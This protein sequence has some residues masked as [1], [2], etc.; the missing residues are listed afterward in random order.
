MLEIGSTAPD[1]TL[2][3][4]GGEDVTLSAL[5]GQKVVLYFYPKDNTPGCTTEALDFTAL[6]DEFAAAGALVFGVSKDSVKKHENFCAK[7]SLGIPLLSDENGSVCEDYG[8]WQEKSMYGKTF[9]GIVRATFL[10]DED[11][12]VAQ[13]WP[14]VK[15]AGHAAEVLEAVKA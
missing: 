1:F 10:I 14:K 11:G 13:V 2:P 3:R 5:R 15:V 8:V 9:M 4:D 12:K 7:H 6:K